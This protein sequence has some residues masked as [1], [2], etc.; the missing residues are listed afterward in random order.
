MKS[1]KQVKYAV[2][3]DWYDIFLYAYNRK[4]LSYVFEKK[5]LENDM[6]GYK[7]LLRLLTKT[8][9][10]QD[11]INRMI[12]CYKLRWKNNSEYEQQYILLLQQVKELDADILSLFRWKNMQGAAFNLGLF[13]LGLYF[14]N[15]AIEKVKL[16]QGEKK[17]KYQ[18]FL[19]AL[20]EQD[21]SYAEDILADMERAKKRE[22]LPGQLEMARQYL[23]IM[24][25][26]EKYFKM[27][28]KQ[29]TIEDKDFYD[30]VNRENFIL[31]GVVYEDLSA[32]NVR[33]DTKMVRINYAGESTLGKA[34]KY[35]NIWMSYYRDINRIKQLEAESAKKEF[36]S[37]EYLI[38]YQGDM[39][40]KY[41]EKKV[42]SASNITPLCFEG[43]S[44]MI[45]IMLFDLAKMGRR[46]I[47]ISG[48]NLFHGKIHD[49]S[50]RKALVDKEENK[51]LYWNSFF[52]H[53]VITQFIMLR[54]L[55]TAG[56]IEPIGVLNDVLDLSL[57]QY[58]EDLEKIYVMCLEETR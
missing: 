22:Y 15:K 7:R 40:K 18:R 51:R 9:K 10:M 6:T 41:L 8:K 26:D 29:L 44:Y 36:Q 28:Y 49:E 31:F 4:R 3:L 47:S 20:E 55:R 33:D 50:Y 32:Y 45:P 14:R 54:N 25:N 34:V 19:I 39:A 24:C 35:K 37:I 11:V 43:F 56:V 13:S 12:S 27:K 30:A 42:H 57:E 16:H 46:K 48:V 2:A 52:N 17:Y 53:S 58:V 38:N 23:S 1:Y 21:Y 5:S